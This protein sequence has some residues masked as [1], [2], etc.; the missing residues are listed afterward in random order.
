MS[1]A[2]LRI[3][4]LLAL[5]IPALLVWLAPVDAEAAPRRP[6]ILIIVTDDQPRGT[7]SVM[8]TTRR[9]FV[10]GGRTYP[11]AYVTTPLCCPS[12][13]SILT[14]RYAHNHGILTQEPQSFDVRTTIARHLRRAGYLTGIAG[15]YL[16]RWGTS[17]D[18][19]PMSPPYFDLW[20]TTRPDPDGYRKTL[21]NV[22]GRLR[23]I[24]RYSTTFI[25]ERTVAFLRTFDRRD[26]RPWL[27][28]TGVIA[29]HSPY[30]ADAAYRNARVSPWPGNAA[31]FE[32]DRTDKPPYV[33]AQNTSYARGR[34]VRARQLRT[35]MSVDDMVDAIF[36]EMA[37]LGE[38]RRTLAFFVS[39]NGLL[40]A[41]HGIVNKTVPYL[42]SVRV[43]LLVRWP[44]RIPAG[45]VDERLAANVDI[46]PTIARVARLAVDGPPMDGRPLFDRGWTRDHLLLEYFAG[47]TGIAPTWASLTA[48]TSQYVEY[49]DEDGNVTFR[50]YYDLIQD[51]WQLTNALGDALPGN[52]PSP[53]ELADLSARLAAERECAG[54]ECP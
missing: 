17:P 47:D 27:M 41:D 40:W 11:N 50:E 4:A 1:P 52:D 54:A 8:P 30:K 10:R 45:S 26:D 5:S 33:Q 49:Y 36:S 2:S 22:N 9:L 7:L 51:P 53:V 13:G 32:E 42:P 14:G 44:G 3:A 37:R 6:N 38:T 12:R 23:T 29:P 46:A 25:G 28:Y 31:V 15:K 18:F 16:N 34:A 21:F 20:A 19:R 48:L 24:D 39:D 35:L 43:P